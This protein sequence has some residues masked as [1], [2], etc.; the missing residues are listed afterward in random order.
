ME[1]RPDQRQKTNTFAEA[2]VFKES[3]KIKVPV[4]YLCPPF[5]GWG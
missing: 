1:V 3:K 4:S 2:T 5:G